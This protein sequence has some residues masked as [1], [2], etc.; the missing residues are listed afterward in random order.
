MKARVSI[1][2]ACLITLLPALS[3]SP[4]RLPAPAPA[5]ATVQNWIVDR[6]YFG[7]S[8]PGGGTVSDENWAAFLAETVTPRFPAGFTTWRAQGQWRDQSGVVVREE[9]FVLELI[10]ADDAASETSVREIIS[11][12]KTR[13]RQE[14]V[15]RVRDRVEVQF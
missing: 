10:H 12:Y 4:A 14:A 3:C 7:R 13:F 5:A 9:T 8:I 15:L 2:V 6:L 11:D 1:V